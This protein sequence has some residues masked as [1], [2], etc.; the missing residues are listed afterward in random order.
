[1]PDEIRL[2]GTVVIVTGAGRGLGRAHAELLAARGAT[3]IVNDRPRPSGTTDPVATDTFRAIRA[4]GGSALDACEDIS[5]GAGARRVV[6]KTI[7]HFGQIDALVN[8][9]GTFSE[10]KAFEDTTI[11]DFRTLWSANFAT[12]YHM[13]QAAWPHLVASRTGRVVNTASTA[14]I[15]GSGTNLDYTAAKGAILAFTL[16][17]AAT[18]HGSVQVNAIAPGG[19]TPM[20]E[21]RFPNE[22]LRSV[23]QNALRSELVSPLVAWLVHEDCT[24]HGQVFEAMAGRVA[25]IFTGGPEG[26]WDRGMTPESLTAHWNEVDDPHGVEY[27]SGFDEWL[28][29]QIERST[30]SPISTQ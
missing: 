29:W 24:A 4:A 9:A 13:T 18:S 25:R 21:D 11:D 6:E 22:P 30:D 27:R 7:D 14:G 19:F 26:F 16:G 20:I 15:Y 3:V 12:T 1:M 23:V 5:S 8:N 28:A 2:D 10:P 17:L